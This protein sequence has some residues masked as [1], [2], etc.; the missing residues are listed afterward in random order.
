GLLNGEIGGFR[1]VEYFGHIKTHLTKN[2]LRVYAGGE[3][4]PCLDVDFEDEHGRQPL[5]DRELGDMRAGKCKELT[6]EHEKH[7]RSALG[8]APERCIEIV[9]RVFQFQRL[10]V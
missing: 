9:R 2:G 3:K 8:E 5:L 4:S 7:L 10:D 1:P 6:G